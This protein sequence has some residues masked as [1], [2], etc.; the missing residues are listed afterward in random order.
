MSVREHYWVRAYRADA[1]TKQG[2]RCCY[3]RSVLT[4][5]TI[6]AEHVVPLSRGGK[7]SDRSNIKASCL[8]CNKAKG[9]QTEGAFIRLIKHPCVEDGLDIRRAWMRRR[10]A[11]A[12]DRACTKLRRFAA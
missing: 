2:G 5:D 12:A 4:C 7:R 8:A 3:C 6:T 9:A 10:I 1:A 11:L